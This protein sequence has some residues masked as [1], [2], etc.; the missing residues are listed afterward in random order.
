MADAASE[1]LETAVGETTTT[2]IQVS[3]ED[4]ASFPATVY[5]G[6]NVTDDPDL[7]DSLLDGTLN[8]VESP[9]DDGRVY[10]PAVPVTYHDEDQKL[11]VLVI[12]EALRHEE[13]ECRSVLLD[14]LASHH[15]VVPEYMRRFEVVFDPARIEEL[16]RR[17][18]GPEADEQSDA[19]DDGGSGQ[20]DEQL[21]E[22]DREIDRL[23]QRLEDVEQQL[24][25]ERDE[26]EQLEQQLEEAREECDRLEDR[27]ETQDRDADALDERA[28]QLESRAD[29]LDERAEELDEREEQLQEVADRVERDSA[30]VDEARQ[31]LEEDRSEFKRRLEQLEER[32][33]ELQVKELNLEQQELD[34]QQTGAAD[35]DPRES[36]QVVTD[37]QFIEVRDADEADELEDDLGEQSSQP[38]AESSGLAAESSEVGNESARPVAPPGSS[39]PE[40]AKATIMTY[41]PEDFYEDFQ[42]VE[43]GDR[44]WFVEPTDDLV[45]VGYRMDDDRAEA[46]LKEE[47]SFLFQLQE[48]DGVPVVTL[49]LG[50]FDDQGDCVDA[51]GAPV[52]DFEDRDSRILDEIGR[53]LHVHLALYG[54]DGGR[55]TAWEAGAPIRR[56]IEWARKRVAD[57]RE[58][59]DDADEHLDEAVEAFEEGDV[60]LVGAMDHPFEVN[61]FVDFEGASDVALAVSIVGY[62]SEDEQFE[63]LI[64]NRSFSLEEFRQI[65][66]RVVRQALHWGIAPGEQLRDVAVEE[67]IIPDHESMVERLLSNYAEVCVGLR[68]N[69]LDPVEQWENWDEL[70][71]LAEAYDVTPDAE[72]LELAEVSLKRAEEYQQTLQEDDGAE[73]EEPAGGDGPRSHPEIDVTSGTVSRRSDESGVSYFVPEDRQNDEFDELMEADREDV[74][75][76]LEE[77]DRRVEAAQV[78]IERFGDGA[79]DVVLE[80]ADKM[81]ESGVSALARFVEARADGLEAVLMRVLDETGPNGTFIAARA[82]AAIESTAAIPRLLEAVCDPDRSGDE[83]RIARCLALFGDK[84]VPPLSEQLQETPEDQD[85]LEVLAG[86]E[87]LRS[88][89]IDELAGQRDEQLQEAADRARELV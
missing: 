8:E 24:E 51:V 58:D 21:E 17:Y 53:E 60:D 85:L 74:E 47:P 35:E 45:V 25:D 12:P 42:E 9:F 37:D 65:Q 10:R 72:M 48:I 83:G 71:D 28:R 16:E 41:D 50:V 70:I 32:E 22:R 80:A 2:T 64:G 15:E 82:L 66:K 88:G 49:T 27:L 38:G 55:L 84:L 78:L 18:T 3:S 29:E 69:D 36:T 67:A 14:R 4:G 30:R 46:F 20:L 52:T 44:D 75:A 33:R 57:W 63:Y 11:F 19:E 89:T 61:R 73:P 26:R 59:R 56:N 5:T 86:L 81:D 54:E 77:A 23:E 76:A 87:Q 34:R 13:F 79:V 68:P 1:R 31:Q 7:R 62:W 39:R 6:V 43:P 40:P